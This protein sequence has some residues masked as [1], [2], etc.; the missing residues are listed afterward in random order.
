MSH[1]GPVHQDSPAYGNLPL[2]V[3]GLTPKLFLNVD[4]FHP[5][6]RNPAVGLSVSHLISQMRGPGTESCCWTVL[7]TRTQLESIHSR[8]LTLCACKALGSVSSTELTQTCPDPISLD[9]CYCSGWNSGGCQMSELCFGGL[10]RNDGN[11]RWEG[12]EVDRTASAVDG[13]K[14]T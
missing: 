12:F 13:G 9:S 10:P 2:L 3:E 4:S 11:K 6:S 8:E 7:V 1:M 5:S 14:Q